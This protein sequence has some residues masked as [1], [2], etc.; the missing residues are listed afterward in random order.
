MLGQAIVIKPPGY[1]HSQCFYEVANAFTDALIEAQIG[2]RVIFGGHL[3]AEVLGDRCDSFYPVVFYQSEQINPECEWLRNR[4]YLENLRKHEVW[5]YSPKN[6]A[7]LKKLGIEAKWVPIRYMPRMT[8]NF[9]VVE[10]DIDVL[11][12]GS[13]NKRR[14]KILDEISAKGLNVR[15]V[16]G[17]YGAERDELIARSKVVLNL[18]YFDE[19]IFEIFRCAHLFA[20]SKCV[21]GETGTDLLLE[22]LY[23]DSAVFCERADIADTCEFLLRKPKKIGEIERQAFE[24]FSVPTLSEELKKIGAAGL[25]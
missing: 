22:S 4:I 15:R 3:L 25:I 12:Y 21:V 8:K 16:F 24:Y 6:V 1:S 23:K 14:V 9:P 5:D 13:T 10:Q 2:K 19:G 18:H 20:N 11:F 17:V 7:A